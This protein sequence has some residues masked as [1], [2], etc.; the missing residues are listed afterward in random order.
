MRYLCYKAG[1]F[2]DW[3]R[4]VNSLATCEDATYQ[5]GVFERI[6]SKKDYF[7]QNVQSATG[8]LALVAEWEDV[9]QW[10]D[11]VVKAEQDGKPTLAFE[12][13]VKPAPTQPS[14]PIATRPSPR[15]GNTAVTKTSSRSAT[16][17]QKKLSVSQLWSRARGKSA[18]RNGVSS[19]G[20]SP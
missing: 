14:N 20:S 6:M 16:Q 17:V 19:A 9:M 2:I 5:V 10:L 4:C 1:Y 3:C 15:E 13:P 12:R 8:P 18:E 11:A 7:T